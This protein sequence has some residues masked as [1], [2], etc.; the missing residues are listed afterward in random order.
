MFAHIGLSATS[1]AAAH[2][3]AGSILFVLRRKYRCI[4]NEPALI[5]AVGSDADLR[6]VVSFV[7]FEELEPK[8]LRGQ[9]SAVLK[10]SAIAGVHGQG[11]VWTSMLSK[12]ANRGCALYELI[13]QAMARVNT[14]SKYDYYRWTRLNECG[15]KSAVM[16]DSLEC[17]GQYFRTCGNL[18]VPNMDSLLADLRDVH[19]HVRRAKELNVVNLT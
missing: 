8:P 7:R 15:Y 18:T 14:H 2:D 19:A 13:P 3:H 10:A 5:E 1:E 12:S 16:P 17:K 4:T 6:K 9:L 11:L